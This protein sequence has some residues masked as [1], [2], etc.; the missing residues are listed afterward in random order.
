[1]HRVIFRAHPVAGAVDAGRGRDAGIDPAA[2]SRRAVVLAV[3]EARQQLPLVGLR[4]YLIRMVAVD[5]LKDLQGI[6]L[7]LD[8]A[9]SAVRQ[10]RVFIVIIVPGQVQQRLVFR[11]RR[12]FVQLLQP[13]T[14]VIQ[15][16]H[17]R[18]AVVRR[19]NRL[20]VPLDQALRVRERAFFLRATR[21]G[22]NK[23]NFRRQ[24]CSGGRGGRVVLPEHCAFRLEP[25][26]E[27][28]SHFKLRSP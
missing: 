25:V 6:R 2:A 4:V 12:A 24:S 28:T 10:A 13:L 11:L 7:A 20:V 3:G 16:P 5:L 8:A 14:E 19:I 22:G 26:G 27:Q 1:M 18:A 21:R 23:E 17:V 9:Q 15:E